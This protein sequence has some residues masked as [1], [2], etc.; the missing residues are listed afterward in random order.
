MELIGLRRGGGAL[1]ARAPLGPIS[2][3]FLQ[4]SGNS[5]PNT[6]FAPQPLGLVLPLGNPGS[7]TAKSSI[8]IMVNPLSLNCSYKRVGTG[9]EAETC[10]RSIQSFFLQTFCHFC[11]TPCVSHKELSS[12]CHLG[13][14]FRSSCWN[15]RCSCFIFSFHSQMAP[16]F[17][18]CRI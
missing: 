8:V 11:L 14:F 13:S 9:E 10:Q 3:I 17:V 2:F 16:V 6:R 12:F 18:I 7:V 1:G 15:S 4:F 5:W